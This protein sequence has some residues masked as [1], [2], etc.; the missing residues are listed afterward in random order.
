MGKPNRISAQWR[1]MQTL[2]ANIKIDDFEDM[3]DTQKFVAW[4]VF[5]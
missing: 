2:I 4:V 5:V 1:E 3:E